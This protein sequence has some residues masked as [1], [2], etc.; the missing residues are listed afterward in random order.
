MLRVALLERRVRVDLGHVCLSDILHAP[1]GPLLY[2]PTHRLCRSGVFLG[3]SPSLF[4]S[5]SPL[6]CSH[7]SR[8]VPP[9]GGRVCA[10][11]VVNHHL[12]LFPHQLPVFGQTGCVLPIPP[13][14]RACE[15]PFPKVVGGPCVALLPWFPIPHCHAPIAEALPDL[16]ITRFE[17]ALRPYNNRLTRLRR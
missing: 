7:S 11:G 10:G 2:L 5:R 8:H 13:Q 4:Q 3:H 6:D 14:C 17:D 15:D 9:R 1:F 12:W 16:D